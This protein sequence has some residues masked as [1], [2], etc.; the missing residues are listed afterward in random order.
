MGRDTGARPYDVVLFGATGFVGE[1]TAEYLADHAP[2]DCRW[3]LAGRSAGKLEAL[4]DRLAEGRPHLAELPLLVADSADPDSLR[5]LAESTRVVATTVGPYVWYGDGLVAACAE[6]GTDCVD[7]TGEA[8]FV[9]LTYVRHD[10]RAR[11]TGARIVHA[12]GFDSVP[13]D[14]GVYFTVRQLPE[15]VPLRVDGFVRA[16]ATFS[17]GTFASALTAFGRGREILRAAHERHLHEPR[18]VGRRARAPIGGPR[19]SRETGTWALPLPTLDPQVV[20]RSAR[21]LDRYGPDFRYRHYASVKTLP[22]AIGG[23]AAIGTGVLAA[24]LPPV[25]EWL[26]NRYQAGQGPSAER[27]ARSWFTVRF[28]GE[29]GGRRVFTEVSGGDPGYDETAKMLAESALC[30]AFDPLPKT[31][32][33]VTTAVAMGD[34]LIERLRAAGIRFRVAHRG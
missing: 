7:L 6:A 31:A 4:R 23:S 18:L 11:E 19:F 10:A 15:D 9:D 21:A 20:A 28:V 12:C 14:L 16:G 13:H 32:G 33:Q 24:Q 8:E 5:E 26:M 27:R 1:L 22:V 2:A 30:L 25:R 17:G 34:A 3:A 29:G